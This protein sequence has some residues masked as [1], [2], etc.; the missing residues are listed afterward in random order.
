[1]VM[2]I[3]VPL[4]PQGAKRPQI[5][6]KINSAYYDS[7]YRDWLGEAK[8]WVENYLVETDFALIKELLGTDAEGNQY[9]N[10]HY[11]RGFKKLDDIEF[12]EDEGVKVVKTRNVM[13]DEQ[14]NPVLDEEGYVISQSG[15]RMPILGELRDDYLGIKVKVQFLLARRNNRKGTPTDKPFP[16]DSNTADLDQYAKAI[17]D[18]FFETAM[19]KETGLNDRHIQSMMLQKRYITGDE[20]QGIRIEFQPI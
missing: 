7:A 13:L 8:S 14:G 19:F 15:Q 17:I 20:S 5:N 10:T 12:K 1:M 18:A 9:L 2:K 4:R 3:E 6:S 16:L 11:V